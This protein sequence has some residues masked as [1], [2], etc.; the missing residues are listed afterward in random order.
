M[1][2][3]AH[4]ACIELIMYTNMMKSEHTAIHKPAI[5]RLSLNFS[6][7]SET[8]YDQNSISLTFVLTFVDTLTNHYN[9]PLISSMWNWYSLCWRRFKKHF[10]IVADLL[11]VC[12]TMLS[13][14]QKYAEWYYQC[15]IC[16]FNT[17]R[18]RQN[19]R[20]FADDIFK[21]IFINEN[22]WCPIK[23]SLKFV[24]WGLINNIPALVQIMAW[25]RPGDKPLSE[26]RMVRL[27]THLCVA[28]PQWVNDVINH[29]QF[30]C[31]SM[32]EV[33]SHFR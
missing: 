14:L 13:R 25:R 19:E 3:F 26:P 1:A 30:T 4:F 12:I 11:V 27:P 9:N 5:N 20:H 28:R 15:N 16:W 32:D 17:L 23:I 22:V 31:K 8:I 21:C 2:I 7:I 29:I 6:T 24:P 33:L 18:P 10:T